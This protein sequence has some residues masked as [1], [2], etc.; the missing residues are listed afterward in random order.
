VVRDELHVSEFEKG[1]HVDDTSMQMRRV[2]QIRDVLDNSVQRLYGKDEEVKNWA[3]GLGGL[4]K[5]QEKLCGL[6][7]G[8]K[9]WYKRTLRKLRDELGYE[10]SPL[11]EPVI[12]V[13]IDSATAYTSYA[14]L[15][16]R[17]L[18][19]KKAYGELDDEDDDSTPNW[20]LTEFDFNISLKPHWWKT[21]SMG[22]FRV[23]VS[24]KKVSKKLIQRET[25]VGQIWVPDIRIGAFIGAVPFQKITDIEPWWSASENATVK[26]LTWR[27]Y[28]NP[29]A[30][31]WQKVGTGTYRRWAAGMLT[32]SGKWIWVLVSYPSSRTIDWRQEN[33]GKKYTPKGLRALYIGQWIYTYKKVGDQKILVTKMKESIQSVGMLEVWKKKVLSPSEWGQAKRKLLNMGAKDAYLGRPW[34]EYVAPPKVES[35]HDS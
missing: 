32:K 9:S 15:V 26:E 31:R 24:L 6:T 23:G 11:G 19:T 25:G 34:K 12:E 22:K 2:R 18:A 14:V 5:V 29:G 16:H 4:K 7:L 21:I 30:L 28:N 35:Q 33:D 3:D 8:S 20:A 17:E 27:F 1:I 10:P 13:P